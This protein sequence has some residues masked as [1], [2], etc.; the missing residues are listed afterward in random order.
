[1]GGGYNTISGTSMAT[2]HVTGA[3][4][5]YRSDHPTATPAQVKGALQ[6]AGNLTWSRSGDPDGIQEP[7]L[8]VDAL[9]GTT[10]GDGTPAP[11]PPPPPSTISLTARGYKRWGRQQVDLSWTGALG[12]VVDV[13]RNGVVVINDTANDGLQT[14]VIGFK[15][16]ATYTYRICQ[17]D[18]TCSN[19]VTVRF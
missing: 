9:V 13:Y 11:P 8:N 12:S 16:S 17:T 19:T 6:S 5:L 7:L 15:G 2:P 3:A 4:A 14:D 1:M 18:N 10:I